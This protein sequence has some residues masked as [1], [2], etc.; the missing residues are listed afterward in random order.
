V[1]A[2]ENWQKG[3]RVTSL[4][5]QMVLH[6][7]MRDP[8]DLYFKIG[9]VCL[10]VPQFSGSINPLYPATH[11]AAATD[12]SSVSGRWQPLIVDRRRTVSRYQFTA[13]GRGAV[14][15]CGL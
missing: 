6:K 10:C 4:S 1:L 13:T 3:C 8:V 9:S 15:D 12:I 7:R 14:L 2:S 5:S 11:C